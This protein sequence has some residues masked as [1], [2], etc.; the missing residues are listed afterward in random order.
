M[1]MHIYPKV[2]NSTK[3]LCI[4]TEKIMHSPGDTKVQ[5]KSLTS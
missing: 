5:Q 2:E 4:I 1:Y 3:K